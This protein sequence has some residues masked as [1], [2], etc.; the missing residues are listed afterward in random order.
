MDLIRTEIKAARKI[1]SKI[2]V[3]REPGNFYLE[4][5]EDLAA[6]F[7]EA[8]HL[9][10]AQAEL[11]DEE[12]ALG[13]FKLMSISFY[14]GDEGVLELSE[15]FKQ[16]REELKENLSMPLDLS[17][18][19]SYLAEISKL[20]S[21]IEEQIVED[22]NGDFHYDKIALVDFKFEQLDNKDKGIY[23]NE[24]K[25]IKTTLRNEICYLNK[26]EKNLRAQPININESNASLTKSQTNSEIIK[27]EAKVFK[28]NS[29]EINPDLYNKDPKKAKSILGEK[30]KDF[31]DVLLKNGFIGTIDYRNFQHAFTNQR[32]IKQIRWEREANELYYLM[33]ELY[34]QNIIVHFKNYW[35]IT[36]KVFIAYHRRSRLATPNSLSRCHPPNRSERLRLLNSVISTLK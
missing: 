17:A 30:L 22:N 2:E 18:K 7:P 28:K 19:E 23:Y 33:K 13:M 4:D 29:F 8:F 3:R 27:K 15:L 26:L 9:T 1:F 11:T 6:R 35:V 24:L 16:V 21:D 5:Y 36:C 20:Y 14:G 10:P 34:E 25:T 32:I 12:K 31:H